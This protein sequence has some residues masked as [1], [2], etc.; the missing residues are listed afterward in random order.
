V[1]EWLDTYFEIVEEQDIDNKESINLETEIESDS[2]RKIMF[3]ETNDTDKQ[4][5]LLF[6]QRN[7]IV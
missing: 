5:Y 4:D 3:G 1:L 2:L 7:H 6:N